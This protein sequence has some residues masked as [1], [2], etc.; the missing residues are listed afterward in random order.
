M[1]RPPRVS[2][3]PGTRRMATTAGSGHDPADSERR[4]AD[5]HIHGPSWL[6][7]LAALRRGRHG[8]DIPGHDRACSVAEARRLGTGVPFPRRH[9]GSRRVSRGQSGSRHRP[10]RQWRPVVDHPHG[11]RARLPRSPDAA[12]LLPGPCWDADQGV[13]S[14]H[15]R[16]DPGGGAVLPRGP[17]QGCDPAH[18]SELQG[19]PAEAVRHDRRA[20][21]ILLGR[22]GRAG[23]ESQRRPRPGSGVRPDPGRREHDRDDLGA[24][25]CP[26]DRGRPA[27][28][29]VPAL[30]LRLC[31]SESSTGAVQRCD[32]P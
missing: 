7:L 14:R 8:R 9:R 4:R 28:V 32:G 27:L 20:T 11:A 21:G 13:R 29:R 25:Q 23:R 17:G 19:H 5:I 1:R 22:S 26:R 2:R 6:R 3:F 31:R 15:A 10:E 12:L 30:L 16:A 24:G 18:E